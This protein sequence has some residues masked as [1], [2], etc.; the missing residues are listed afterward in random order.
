MCVTEAQSCAAFEPFNPTKAFT[1]GATGTRTVRVFLR[2]GRGNTSTAAVAPQDSII[3][4]NA[5]P[6]GG[7][8]T[9]KPGIASLQLSWTAATDALSGV[10]RYRVMAASAPPANCTTGSPVYEGPALSFTH[11]GLPN[12]TAVAYRVCAVDGAGNVATG[13]TATGTPRAE[14]TPPTGTLAINAGAAFTKATA[15]TLALTAQDPAGVASMCVTTAA[16]C[17]TYEPFAATKAWT[18]PANNGPT[19]LRLFLVDKLGNA[20]TTPAATATIRLDTTT[21]SGGALVGQAGVSQVALS[22]TAATDSGSGVGSYRVVFAVGAAPASCATGTVLTEA[23]VRAFTHTGLLNQTSYGYRV[24]A[25]DRVGNVAAGV[26]A[27]AQ[28]RAEFAAPTGSVVINNGAAF[29][30]TTA[31]TVSVT[32]TDASG[33]GGM[34]LS[35]TS[36]ACTTF[37]PFATTA[38]VTLP[39]VG[40]IQTVF[41]TL[42]DTLGNVTPSPLRDSITLDRTAPVFTSLSV[43]GQAAGISFAWSAVDDAVGVAGYRLVV[44]PGTVAPAAA[45]TSGTQLYDGPATSFVDPARPRGSYAYRLCARDAAGNVNEGLVVLVNVL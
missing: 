1:L 5:P 8:L 38:T 43:V 17:T 18:L 23:N 35:T 4:D 6:A 37:V 16:T 19:T 33:I 29:T 25:I 26:T 40:G 41:V 14:L 27:V 34:C 39:N 36:A 9:V 21:P 2:D 44:V 24:C 42:R 31:V 11:T 13:V 32:A 12:G 45:C 30:A 3:F 22:W 20:S 7:A 10:A 28:P 15:V